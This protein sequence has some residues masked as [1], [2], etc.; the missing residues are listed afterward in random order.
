LAALL[1]VEQMRD[2]TAESPMLHADARPGGTCH[3]TEG[4]E[5]TGHSFT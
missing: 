4:E 1:G 5:R 2:L 3:E